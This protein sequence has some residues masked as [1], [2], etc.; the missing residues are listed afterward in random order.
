MF[1][2]NIQRIVICPPVFC[3]PDLKV[4]SWFWNS[5]RLQ[6]S[7]ENPWTSMKIHDVPEIKHRRLET[8]WHAMA[9][10]AVRCWNSASCPG[11]APRDFLA[12]ADDS[13]GKKSRVISGKLPIL[14]PYHSHIFRDSYGNSMGKGSQYWGSLKIPLKKAL[15]FSMVSTGIYGKD[16]PILYVFHFVMRK[17]WILEIHANLKER[18]EEST[19]AVTNSVDLVESIWMDWNVGNNTVL[20]GLTFPM[21]QRLWRSSTRSATNE[22]VKRIAEG[23]FLL[24]FGPK[25]HKEA[26]HTHPWKLM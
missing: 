8:P 15:W 17:S 20:Q 3:W 26:Y 9:G 23:S 13:G 19:A 18:L 2:W 11:A 4:E 1:V 12:M 5:W 22:M 24:S 21:P 6:T 16:I 14:F 10:L 7:W 25:R